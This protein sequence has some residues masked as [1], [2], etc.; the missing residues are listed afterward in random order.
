MFDIKSLWAKN[1]DR[2]KKQRPLR[3]GEE[4]QRIRVLPRRQHKDN[5]LRYFHKS[6]TKFFLG[7]V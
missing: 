3:Q 4:E 2:R 6:V 1:E 7:E 5:K